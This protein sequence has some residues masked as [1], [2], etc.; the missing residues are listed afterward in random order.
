MPKK[1]IL[2]KHPENGR[3]LW[4][5]RERAGLTQL[6]LADLVGINRR[7]YHRLENGEHLPGWETRARLAEVLHL[8]LDDILVWDDRPKPVRRRVDEL[9]RSYIQ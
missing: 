2:R 4:R 9:T 5:A 7:H 8:E 6:Q 3:A 1:P